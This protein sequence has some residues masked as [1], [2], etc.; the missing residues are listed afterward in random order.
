LSLSLPLPLPTVSFPSF[1]SFRSS[2]CIV[3]PSA[4]TLNSWRLALIRPP[5]S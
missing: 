3:L 5:S 1:T 4:R 2:R